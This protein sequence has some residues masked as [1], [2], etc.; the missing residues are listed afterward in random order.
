MRKHPEH[1]LL[2]EALRLVAESNRESVTMT[3]IMAPP[4]KVALPGQLKVS[5]AQRGK[6]M[7][8]K[9]T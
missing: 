1:G 8:K 6:R 5:P 7:K 2:A 4:S 9:K 3:S